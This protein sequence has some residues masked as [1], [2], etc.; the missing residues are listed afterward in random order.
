MKIGTKLYAAKEVGGTLEGV[1]EVS[2]FKQTQKSFRVY[3]KDQPEIG[4]LV[5]D[6][7]TFKS[8]GQTS[9]TLFH[10]ESDFAD[11]V[12][13]DELMVLIREELD[14][15]PHRLAVLSG[16]LTKLIDN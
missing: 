6:N 15:R 16:V 10:S 9:Y 8:I 2:V 11:K 13:S 14:L 5:F 3:N 1:C 4:R 12:R 7:Q